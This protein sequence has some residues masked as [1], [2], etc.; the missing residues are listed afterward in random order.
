MIEGSCHVHLCEL[1]MEIG[2]R[3][4]QSMELYEATGTCP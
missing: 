2:L 4:G 3:S 1:G